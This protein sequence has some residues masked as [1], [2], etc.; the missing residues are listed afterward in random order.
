MKYE[1][2]YWPVLQGRGEFVRLVMEDGG[3]EYADVA[4]LPESD[5]GGFASVVAIKQALDTGFAPPYLRIGNQVLSQTAVICEYLAPMAG[6]LPDSE[7]E[8]LA[9]RQHLLTVLDVVNEAHDTHHPLGVA[10]TYE[11]QREAAA[12]TART[13]AGQRIGTRLRHFEAVLAASPGDSLLPSSFCYADTALF[14]LISGLEYAFPT[15]MAELLPSLP[16]CQALKS[17]VAERPRLAAYLRSDRRL[18]FN[19]NGIFRRYPELDFPLQP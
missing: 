2:F 18:P 14:Q 12:A 13:F 6:L 8:V 7:A 9:A 1:L 4:R 5:G 16:H 11:E 3:L 15:A 10:L 19:E 17:M